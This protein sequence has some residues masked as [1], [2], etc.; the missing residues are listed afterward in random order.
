MPG[1]L[2]T[3]VL[4]VLNDNA[5]SIEKNVGAMSGYLS[6]LRIDPTLVAP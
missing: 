5:M 3:P 6:K 2:H 4:V 1:H